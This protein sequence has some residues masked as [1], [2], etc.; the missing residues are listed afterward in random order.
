MIRIILVSICLSFLM[1]ASAQQ[2]FDDDWLFYRGNAQGA[3]NPAFND[4]EWRKVDLP[5]DWSIED[6]PGTNSPFSPGAISQVSGG[7]TTGGTGWYRKHFTVSKKTPKLILQFDGV[8]MNATIW[9][10]GKKL[11]KHPYGYT[12]FS[13]DITDKVEEGKENVLAVLVRNEGEN[14][15][16]YAGSGIYRHVW[17]KSHQHNI[18]I[19]TPLVNRNAA[20]VVIKTNEQATTRIYNQVG[21]LVAT[22]PST[23]S[24]SQQFHIA[25]PSLWSVDTPG[26]YKAITIIDTDTITTLFG[27]RTFTVDAVNGARLNGIPIKLKGGCVHHDNGPLGAKAYDRAEERKVALLKASGYNAIRCAHNPPSPAFLDACDRLG[28]LVV[29]E[30]FDTWKDP[31]NPEDYHVF[32]NDWWQRDLES[33]VNRD[34]N[35]PAVIMWSIGNEIPHREKPEVAAVA[36]T[37][38]HYLLQLDSTRLITCGVNGIAPDKDTFLSALDVAGYNYALDKYEPDHAR[39]PNRVIMATESFPL[40]A[41]TYWEGVIKHPWVIGDFVWTAFDYIGEASIGWLGY[42]QHQGFYPWN[43]AYCGDIDICGWKRPQ[44]YYRDALWM[45]GQL[46]LFVHPPQPTYALNPDKIDWSRWEWQDVSDSWNWPGNEGKPLEVVA[47]SSYE[48]VELFL[49]GKSLGKK[50]VKDHSAS[51]QVPYTAGTLTAVAGKKKATLVTTGPAEK[52]QLQSDTLQLAP[53]NQDL[54]YITVNVLDSAGH[55]HRGD[56]SMINFKVEG[57]ATIV[58]V[59]N[60]D[61]RSLESNQ[62]ARRKAFHGRA[63]V[64]IKAGKTPGAIRLTASSPNLQAAEITFNSA[65][66]QPSAITFNNTRPQWIAYEEMPD[67]L[68][69]VPG[70]PDDK[71]KAQQRT[72]TPLFRKTFT[73][74]QPVKSA[75]LSI[76]GLGHY[77]CT[78]NG[79]KVGN[80]FLAPGW[81]NY[82]KRVLYNS[83]DITHYLKNGENAIGVIVGNGFYYINKERYHKLLTAF[84]YP[85]MYCELELTY[86]DGSRT[87]IV[88]DQSWKTAPSPVTYTSIYGGEDYDAR[89]EQ[90]GWDCPGFD[91]Q[92]WQ[93]ALVVK[94]PKGTL[95]EEKDY[96]V[97]LA[98]SIPVKSVHNNVY[99]FGQNASG[100][101]SLKIKGH[102]GQTIQ[103]IPAELL[104]STGLANQRA[105]GKPYYYSYTLK[106]NQ[107]EEWQ[108][109]FTYTGFRYVQVEGARPDQIIDLKL[110]HNRNSSPENGSFTCSN[111]LFN[112]IYDLVKWAI[113]SNLQSVATDCPHREKLGWLEQDYLMGNSIQFNYDV[114]LLYQ[115]LVRDMIDAQTPEGLVPDIAPEYVF[116]DDKGFGFRD[117]PEWGS[118]CVILPWLLYK[119]YGDIGTMQ[120]AYPMMQRY[121]AYLESKANNH[122]L[123][124]GLGDWFDYGPARPGVAQLTPKDLTATAIY[125]YDCKLMADMAAVLKKKD[126]GTYRTLAADIKSAF[127]NKFFNKQTNVYAT[128]SQTA[129]AMPLCTGLVDETNKAAVFKN[130]TD[131]IIHN[132]NKLTAGDIGFHFLV[133]ALQEGGASQL[134]YDMN[135]RNDVPGYGYQI[136]KGATALT[137]SWPALAEVSN[138]HLMLG[139]IIEWFYNGLAGIQ[140]SA[141]SIA[142]RD[143]VIKPEI[144]GDITHVKASYHIPDGI[145]RSEWELKNQHFTLHVSIPS[146]TKASI[147]LPITSAQSISKNGQKIKPTQYENGRA[148]IRISSGEYTFSVY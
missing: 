49:N 77:E 95:E 99:D 50:A 54:A 70:L 119:W 124:Y 62:A 40:D 10:N 2:L 136:A 145:I 82:D 86:L 53:N 20:T 79:K 38:R 41:G 92:S 122:I 44:S 96:P 47:Y 102:K 52:L 134:I 11:G 104:T 58:G 106:G 97:T 76:T 74:T 133:Q 91:D 114:R 63:L 135:C 5:H 19:T 108:P 98:E 69:L 15:R 67:S 22:Q 112:Q 31:K 87:T 46:S 60:A 101:I 14:S 55:R 8:Y 113:K 73:T 57:P 127:N 89:L 115:K 68:R 85:K 23:P 25:K 137:E 130:L 65:G 100:I 132:N 147:M 129:M 36:H 27:I 123:S 16:W 138:N 144:V 59:G 4:K 12:T 90:D 111:P 34:R 105:T 75:R 45:P 3:E 125:Y 84:G 78:I 56:T 24:V 143:I 26:L 117:S 18:F 29:D 128:G 140:Q 33:M 6:L 109:R 17:L 37:L 13:Y 121:I 72:V 39:V 21:V 141:S 83:Y 88:S 94:A 32:F 120:T 61:P 35:H 107:V 103:L 81:T 131:S 1:P 30:A 142:Y 7:F 9:L 139:H 28:M 71:T 51:W 146:N 66:L 48:Q 110:L 80:H 126:A 93:N 43:L 116:F 64:I 118:A 42:M 148:V